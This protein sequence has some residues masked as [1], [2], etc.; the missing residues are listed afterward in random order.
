MAISQSIRP[1]IVRGSLYWFVGEVGFSTIKAAIC[2]WSA[3]EAHRL[4]IAEPIDTLI[5]QRT[6]ALAEMRA[7]GQDMARFNAASKREADLAARIRHLRR[8]GGA[9]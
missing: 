2:A 3:A 1:G 7:A 4:D 9:S 8:G 5:V 6:E